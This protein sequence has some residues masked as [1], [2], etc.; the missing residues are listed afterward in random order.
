MELRGFRYY[1][2][3]NSPNMEKVVNAFIAE[4]LE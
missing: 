4:H 2:D 1:Q 3:L